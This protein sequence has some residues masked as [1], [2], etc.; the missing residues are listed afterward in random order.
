[1]GEDNEHEDVWA[2]SACDGNWVL[3]ERSD[4]RKC[5]PECLEG[6]QLAGGQS[7]SSMSWMLIAE[8][9]SPQKST[10]LGDDAHSSNSVRLIMARYR[11]CRCFRALETH[12]EHLSR[13]SR[14]PYDTLYDWVF[15][16]AVDNRF[17]IGI[18]TVHLPPSSLDYCSSLP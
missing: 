12:I 9:I 11:Y 6:T 14:P 13:Y 15:G 7:S 8:F 3:E 4:F 17:S 5:P 10:N 1:V 18:G 16:K 2:G